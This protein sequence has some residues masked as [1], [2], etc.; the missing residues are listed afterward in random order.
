M[1]KT[2]IKMLT[3]KNSILPLLLFLVFFASFLLADKQTT[4]NWDDSLEV[5]EKIVKSN[6]IEAVHKFLN[7]LREEKEDLAVRGSAE[8]NLATVLGNEGLYNSALDYYYAAIRDYKK[9]KPED[10]DLVGWMYLNQGNLFYQIKNDTSAHQSFLKAMKI[11]Q[12]P[13]KNELATAVVYNNLGLVEETQ[14]KLDKALLYYRIGFSI[15]TKENNVFQI[16]HSANYLAEI[17]TQLGKGD[18]ARF[19]Y[20]LILDLEPQIADENLPHYFPLLI[21]SNL[22]I[23]KTKQAL[24]DL[25]WFKEHYAL[26]DIN[27]AI[28]TF[29]Q[30][31]H[32]LKEQ[33]RLSEAVVILSEALPFVRNNN[34]YQAKIHILEDL[35]ELS[36]AIGQNNYRYYVE[37]NSARKQLMEVDTQI[38]NSRLTIMK[39]IE[40]Y[41]DDKLSKEMELKRANLIKI[42][43]IIVG[44]L[45]SLLVIGLVLRYQNIKR[46]SREMLRKEQIIHQ[47]EIEKGEIIHQQ[48]IETKRLEMEYSLELSQ[49]EMLAK[50]VVFT[51]EREWLAE[52]Y[53]S[54]T[55]NENGAILDAQTLRKLEQ[56]LSREDGWN[57]FNRW[58]GA[59]HKD[60][61]E[62][63]KAL[64]PGL[65]PSE[66]KICG[67]IKLKMSTKD[68]ANLTRL[69]PKSIDGYRSRIRQKLQLGSGEN[70][71]LFID[72][73]G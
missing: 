51:Q 61:Y 45:L 28:K 10:K 11:F 23:G 15:R 49:K 12:T 43:L 53:E 27:N 59:V 62:K 21:Y 30:A 18:S 36:A 66:L 2:S 71:T 44:V 5:A 13:P 68:I 39:D 55:I 17:F 24:D 47:Q 73:L 32:S 1:G 60:F 35:I 4:P 26:V 46:V 3:V 37:L 20:E 70:L 65:S 57:E 41:E 14:M 16:A 25:R 29:R 58:F 64:A 50:A 6:P 48:E 33:G 7:I 42:F 40:R 19:Y 67:L 72:N 38:Y 54:M 69:A 63:L 9:A 52:L 31:A 22:S 8:Q 34:F 56:K